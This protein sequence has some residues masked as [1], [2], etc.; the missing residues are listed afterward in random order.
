MTKL[1]TNIKE[2]F[3]V[4]YTSIKKVL[5]KEMNRLPTLKNDF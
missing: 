2:L 1:F 4:R 5:G 3:Q